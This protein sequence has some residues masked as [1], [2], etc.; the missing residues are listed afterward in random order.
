MRPDGKV[1]AQIKLPETAAN[2]AWA[3]AGRTLYITAR[4]GV[5][6]LKVATPGVMP[7]YQK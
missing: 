4:T 2:L 5:Y 3:D 1:L 6:R 7:L